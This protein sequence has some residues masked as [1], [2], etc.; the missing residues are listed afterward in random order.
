MINENSDPQFARCD[1]A[2]KRRTNTNIDGF[3]IIK[4]KYKEMGSKTV[5]ISELPLSNKL[6]NYSYLFSSFS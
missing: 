2:D 6:K 5:S 1:L 3:K 4:G